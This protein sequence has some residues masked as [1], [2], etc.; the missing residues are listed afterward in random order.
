MSYKSSIAGVAALA[1]IARAAETLRLAWRNRPYRV[2]PVGLALLGFAP[3][4]PVVFATS[5]SGRPT[6]AVAVRA[7]AHY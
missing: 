4:V 7:S 1:P 6:G 2:P 5:A 3:V